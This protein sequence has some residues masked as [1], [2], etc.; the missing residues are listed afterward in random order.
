METDYSFLEEKCMLLPTF[1][2]LNNEFVLLPERQTCPLECEIR[3]PTILRK[4]TATRQLGNNIPFPLLSAT[5][6]LA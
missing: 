2:T 4:S 5:A 3:P 6:V 1:G